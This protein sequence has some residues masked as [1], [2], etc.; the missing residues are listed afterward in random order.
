MVVTGLVGR[1]NT[2]HMLN[3]ITLTFSQPSPAVSN[4]DRHSHTLTHTHTHAWQCVLPQCFCRNAPL[5]C[6]SLPKQLDA[7]EPPE[8]RDGYSTLQISWGNSLPDHCKVVVSVVVEKKSVTATRLY[9]A[10]ETP[11]CVCVGALVVV[12]IVLIHF[13]RASSIS[14]R[15]IQS[16]SL[17]RPPEPN[18]TM[19]GFPSNPR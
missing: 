12:F 17:H 7:D 11:C 8:K 10:M 9:I 2:S 1:L 16:P 6:I 14:M 5:H 3:L 18:A 15:I 13:L 19:S 4:V